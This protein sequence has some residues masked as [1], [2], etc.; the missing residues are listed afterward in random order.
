MD[1]SAVKA[2]EDLVGRSIKIEVDGKIFARNARGDFERLIFDPGVQTA[3]IHALTG[4]IDFVKANVDGLD[5]NK[6][7]AL[8]ESPTSVILY[9]AV[10]G[11]N[12][13]RDEV[14]HVEIDEKLQTY[15]FGYYQEV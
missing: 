5:F 2:M 9:S 1:N 12:R 13:G 4:L 14:V 6:H 10:F 3:T 8:V 11:D 7:F 15:R